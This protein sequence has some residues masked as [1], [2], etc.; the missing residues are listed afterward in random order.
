MDEKREAIP[1]NLPV[2]IARGN[3]IPEAWENSVFELHE[4]GLNYG[5]DG[6]KDQGKQQTDSTMTI[7][8]QRP[9]SKLFMHKGMTCSWEDLLEYQMEILGAKDAWVD[10]TEKSTRWEYHY[11]ERLAG[12]PGKTRQVDQIE[13]MIQKLATEPFKRNIN[14][15]TWVPERDLASKDPP[16]LQRIWY[17][18]IPGEDGQ[19]VL[20]MNYNF[21]SRNVMIAAPMN[22][23]GLA[24]LFQYVIDE[25]SQRT[26]KPIK[27]GR[28]V[29]FNDA[30]HVS[31]RDQPIFRKFVERI[32]PARARGEPIES[33]VYD[34]EMVFP[35][36][37]EARGK[38]EDR[39]L[40]TTQEIM[41]ETGQ[42]TQPG[43][44]DAEVAKVKRIANT[45]MDINRRIYEGK[46]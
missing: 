40:S 23:V 18:M 41:K 21:R 1:G 32:S 7:E 5:R 27:M 35:M 38:I 28:M 19:P 6:P 37:E 4:H 8:I 44:Y 46:I 30:Y 20:N 26:G 14:A 17:T 11:H 16:C 34:M 33:R 39:I 15:V 36:L 24:T 9:L 25:V 12:H 3:S 2:L 13:G 22:Q 10:P 31:A 45:V 42:Y 29:D 43:A